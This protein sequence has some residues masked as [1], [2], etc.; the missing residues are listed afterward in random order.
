MIIT[1]LSGANRK[2]AMTEE[3]K[4]FGVARGNQITPRRQRQHGHAASGSASSASLDVQSPEALEAQVLPMVDEGSVAVS[5]SPGSPSHEASVVVSLP[6][7]ES[8][9][10]S[11]ELVQEVEER[12]AEVKPAG[13]YVPR[14]QRTSPGQSQRRINEE[15]EDYDQ[16]GDRK[17]EEEEEEMPVVPDLLFSG[18]VSGTGLGTRGAFEVLTVGSS[19]SSESSSSSSS[20]SSSYNTDNA[21]GQQQKESGRWQ[22][23]P[24]D[25][26]ATL[27]AIQIANNGGQYHLSDIGAGEEE[28][29]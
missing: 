3:E 20:S 26:K 12:V 29:T 6:T 17:E 13:P 5:M 21:A 27:E 11:Q 4:V 16:D 8:V 2:G 22:T 10:S 19:E 23:T 18:G 15:K 7:H 28:G 14:N 1:Q 25:R 9:L 24:A